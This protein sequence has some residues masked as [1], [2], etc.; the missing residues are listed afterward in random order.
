MLVSPAEARCA[1]RLAGSGTR[2]GVDQGRL[3]RDHG[4]SSQAKQK[5]KAGGSGEQDSRAG[6]AFSLLG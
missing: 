4:R 2:R 1:H 5:N 6:P 3:S